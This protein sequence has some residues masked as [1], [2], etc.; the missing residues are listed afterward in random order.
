MDRFRERFLSKEQ[1]K[2]ANLDTTSQVRVVDHSG[3]PIEEVPSPQSACAIC[4]ETFSSSLHICQDVAAPKLDPLIGKVIGER[5]QIVELIGQGGMSHVYKARHQILNKFVAVKML[6]FHLAGEERHLMRFKRE[7]KTASSLQHPNIASVHDFGIMPDGQPFLVMD[8]IEGETMRDRIRRE[9]ISARDCVEL[10]SQ[11]CEALRYAHQKGVVHRDMKPGNVILTKDEN[12]TDVVKVVDFGIAKI[13]AEED[14][15]QDLTKTGESCGSPPYMS[16]EQCQGQTLDARSDIYSMG[17]L[18][19]ES[20]TGEPPLKGASI[21]ETIRMQLEN[22]PPS[23]REKKPDT[24]LSDEFDSI[25]FK[26]MAKRPDDRYANMSDLKDALDQLFDHEVNHTFFDQCKVRYARWARRR[27]TRA[28]R[29]STSSVGSLALTGLVV[30]VAVAAGLAYFQNTISGL[31]SANDNAP[32]QANKRDATTPDER[33]VFEIAKARD[34]MD[35]RKYQQAIDAAKNAFRLTTAFP[36][37]DVRPRES[38]QILSEALHADNQTEQADIVDKQLKD[39]DFLTGNIRWSDPENNAARILELSMMNIHDKKVAEELARRTSLQA[40][41]LAE[42]GRAIEAE[43]YIKQVIEIDKRSIGRQHPEY[44]RA[45]ANLGLIYSQQG[46]FAAAEDLY[47]QAYE[48]RKKALGSEHRDTARALKN[49]AVCQLHL[50]K[51]NEAQEKL[52]KA[53]VLY[54]KMPNTS[55][56]GDCLD[57]LGRTYM[58]QDKFDKAAELF[59]AAID[60]R[61]Q[62]FGRNHIAVGESVGGLAEVYIQTGRLGEARELSKNAYDIAVNR[63]GPESLPAADY[64]ANLGQIAYAQADYKTA[65]GYFD[66]ALKIRKQKQ[67]AGHPALESLNNYLRLCAKRLGQLP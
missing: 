35:Q 64:L 54:N 33:W 14:Q 31:N 22:M 23:V 27:K 65:Q 55:D 37:A 60:Q 16:P 29:T 57:S 67:P 20:L 48:I 6:R 39:I 52:Q 62:I 3:M 12:G 47:R 4:S 28:H 25:V 9:P 2:V 26:C 43:K 38:L 24:E 30:A 61:K 50:A 7:A 1:D 42:S 34:A 32:L 41:L 59:Q 40:F 13:I 15:S 56:K 17:C 66:N 63:Y 10:F 44:A 8:F 11:I 18:L 58:Q 5:Y 49:Y 36:P 21:Y 51:T 53:L 45:I 46:R 19:F